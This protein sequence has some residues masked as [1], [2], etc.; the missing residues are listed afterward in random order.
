[1]QFR[2]CILILAVGITTIGRV[3]AD[4][5]ED[6]TV[7]AI[8]K[9]GGKVER[10]E[11]KPGKPV[12]RVDFA[13]TN[14]TEDDLSVLG[15]L[16]E[17]TCLRF[18][19]VRLSNANLDQLSQLKTLTTLDFHGTEITTYGLKQVAKIQGLN[20][21]NLYQ[22][23]A[24]DAGLKELAPLKKLKNPTLSSQITNAGLKELTALDGLA[25][26]SFSTT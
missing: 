3:S 17:L 5:A 2:N 13:L 24:T 1:M 19:F 10:D 4:E 18:W 16:K 12:V 15:K 25:T 21:L 7:A 8:E 22:S 20:C 6:P 11:T 26:L 9:L 23:E 14:L